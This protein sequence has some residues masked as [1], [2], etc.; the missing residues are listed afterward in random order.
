MIQFIAGIAV[1]AAFAPFWMQVW[2][3]GTEVVKAKFAKG[4]INEDQSKRSSEGN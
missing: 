3:W 2:N 4:G 1:G